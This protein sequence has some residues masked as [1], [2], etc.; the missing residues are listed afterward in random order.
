M[1]KLVKGYRTIDNSEEFPRE[2]LY[3]VYEDGRV[4][5]T[6][7]LELTNTHFDKPNRSWIKIDALP[8]DA[9]WIGH[10]PAPIG[11]PVQNGYRAWL[12]PLCDRH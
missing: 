1:T 12:V 11:R 3:A 5:R 2:V 4:F 9:E 8:E 7:L 10:Y 6:P